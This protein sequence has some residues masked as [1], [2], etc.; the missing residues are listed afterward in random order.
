MVPAF[1]LFRSGSRKT[2][3]IHQND[4]KA[5]HPIQCLAR[6]DIALSYGERELEQ[7]EWRWATRA[8][9]WF[10]GHKTDQDQLG[11]ILVRTRDTASGPCSRPDADGDAVAVLV[12]LLS[13]DCTLPEHTPLSAFRTGETVKVWDYRQATRALRL[14]A[15]Q[16][17]LDPQL[18][19]LHSL[20][21]GT[22]TVL[23]AGGEIAEGGIQREGRWKSGADTYKVYTR[24]NIDDSVA[25]S[26]KLTAAGN[27]PQTQP[28]QGT[29][30]KNT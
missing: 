25:V 10:Q 14:I 26:R 28:G 19:S 4:A 7:A 20:R 8:K 16:K 17:G 9:I 12:E 27:R 6:K 23:A 13:Y 18:V 2:K 30:W 11:T 29:I 15:G 5:V 24:N 22:A 1:V 21:I 3:R